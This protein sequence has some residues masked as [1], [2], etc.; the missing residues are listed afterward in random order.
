MT[1][2]FDANNVHADVADFATAVYFLKEH[3]KTQG[4]TV[5]A[6]GDGVAASAI[7]SDVITSPD[8]GANGFDNTRAWI[9]LQQPSGGSGDFAGSRQFVFQRGDDATNLNRKFRNVYSLGGTA[10][11][12]AIDANTVPTFTDEGIYVGGGTPGSPTFADAQENVTGAG[13]YHIM[14]GGSEDNFRWYLISISTRTHSVWCFDP[15]SELTA[16]DTDPYAMYSA[17]FAD[18]NGMTENNMNANS[19][20]RAIIDPA[21]IGTGVDT[22]PQIQKMKGWPNSSGEMKQNHVTNKED[23]IFPY[24]AGAGVLKGFKGVSTIWRFRTISHALK[25]TYTVSI[26]RDRFLL[27]D[28]AAEWNGS[29]PI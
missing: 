11:T 15:L 3:L 24:Y 5:V 22:I 17:V 10:N 1:I 6:S 19:L 13:A 8:D 9:C 18:T 16:G 7:G 23:L 27:E 20:G 4:W 26:S 28:F 21:N 25:S 12:G 2:T 29:I 14:A